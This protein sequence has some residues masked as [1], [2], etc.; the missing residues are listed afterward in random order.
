M[1]T[2]KIDFFVPGNPKGLKR[3]RTFRTK[4]GVNI[5]VDPSKADKA[6]FLA[7]AMSHRPE[8]PIDGPLAM[9]VVCVFQRPKAHYRKSGELRPDAPVWYASAP[10]VDNCYKYV[11]DALNGVF[12]RDDRQIAVG[13]VYAIYGSVPGTAVLIRRPCEVDLDAAMWAFGLC[14]G[15]KPAEPIVKPVEA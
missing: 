15:G 12:W 6:D 7:M 10:D 3:H 9:A 11:A 13:M 8:A 4:S 5:Q 2:V 14:L 1:E